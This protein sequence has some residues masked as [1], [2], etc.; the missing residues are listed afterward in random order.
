MRQQFDEHTQRLLRQTLHISIARE[1]ARTR[2]QRP[3]IEMKFRCLS[4]LRAIIK[5]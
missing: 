3:A 5:K 4:H 1:L 2:S